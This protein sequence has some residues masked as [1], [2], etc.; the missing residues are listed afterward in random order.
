MPPQRCQLKRWA[1]LALS[2]RRF[3]AGLYN[4]E[5]LYQPIVDAWAL[6]DNSGIASVFLKQG[7]L[8]DAHAP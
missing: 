6:Y 3:A 8:D 5:R 1:R 4:F 7:F 2:S